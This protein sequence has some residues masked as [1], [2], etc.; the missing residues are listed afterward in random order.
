LAVEDVI[1][2]SKVFD[3]DEERLEYLFKLLKMME[4]KRKTPYFK[5][6]KVKEKLKNQNNQIY[7]R[8]S[9]H[10]LSQTGN[11][12]KINTMEYVKYKL[13]LFKSRD[14]QYLLKAPPTS[15]ENLVH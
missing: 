12:T 5:P 6:K 4:E 3:S 9:K 15:G 8:F 14:A 1:Y 13:V 11:S 10:K 2:R 7:A